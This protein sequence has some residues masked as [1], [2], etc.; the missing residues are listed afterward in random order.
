MS[1]WYNLKIVTPVSFAATID[2]LDHISVI[3]NKLPLRLPKKA[4]MFHLLPGRMK[5]QLPYRLQNFKLSDGRILAACLKF[6]L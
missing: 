6:K 5:H 2:P 1:Y 4:L 3:Q